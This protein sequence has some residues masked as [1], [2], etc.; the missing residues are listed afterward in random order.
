MSRFALWDRR[1]N[2]EH[3]LDLLAKREA[4]SLDLSSTSHMVAISHSSTAGLQA[5]DG[6]HVGALVIDLPLPCPLPTLAAVGVGLIEEARQPQASYP[7]L[8]IE[9]RQHLV[10]VG[11]I[12]DVSLR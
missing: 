1:Q 9:R 8:P 6:G 11:I 10:V 7:E 2:S 4:K 12:D 3:R 5:Q